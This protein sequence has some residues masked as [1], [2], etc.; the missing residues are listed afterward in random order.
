MMASASTG[1]DSCESPGMDRER[2][3]LR[4]LIGP[5][6]HRSGEAIDDDTSL[7]ASGILDSLALFR[8]VVWIEEKIGRNLDPTSMD[9]VRECDSMRRI[10]DFVRRSG[11]DSAPGIATETSARPSRHRSGVDIVEYTPEHKQAVLFLQTR[12]W[13][14]D[15]DINRRYF[16]WKYARNPYCSDPRIYLALAQ[17]EVVGMRGFYPSCWEFGSSKRSAAVLV[18][19]DLTI[20]EDRRNQGLMTRIMRTALAD[21]RQHGVEYVFNLSGGPLT[22]LGSVAMGWRSVTRLGPIARSTRVHSA[23]A[24]F[25]RGLSKVRYLR[26]FS[27]S[28][29]LCTPAERRPFARIDAAAPCVS[30][31]GVTVCVERSARVDAMAELIRRK[32]HDGRIRHVR[33]AAFL[34][35][36][37][38]NP[39][40]EYR[41]LYAGKELLDG[42]LILQR[43][44]AAV[45]GYRVSIVDLEAADDRTR[46]ALVEVAIR[47]GAFA[48][49]NAWSAT[50]DPSIVAVMRHMGFEASD[51]HRTVHGLPCIL[52]RATDD[53]RLEDDWRIHGMRL[54]DAAN[55]DHRMIYTSAG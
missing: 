2:D 15:P 44:V 14:T 36:R 55:W 6:E 37:F 34:A 35:W 45:N 31:L 5:C 46:R 9:L 4:A 50:L 3:E 16:D 13:S 10:L 22:V 18:A 8:L 53:T 29:R 38:A 12:L 48:E 7:I 30:E 52:V 43:P 51:R 1:V 25:R 17:G 27:S 33:D 24:G 11:V 28:A 41:F 23:A 20:R 19:D 54:V 40:H 21:L 49:L 42:Y 39:L 32:P 26:R 47:H